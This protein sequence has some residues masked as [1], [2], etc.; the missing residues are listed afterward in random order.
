MTDALKEGPAP[1]ELSLVLIALMKGVLYKA[2]QP[3]LWEILLR[4]HAQV[5]DYVGVL[6]LQL[7]LSDAEGYAYLRQIEAVEEEELPR[8]VARRQLGYHVSLLLALLRKKLAEHDTAGGDPRLILT[9]DQIADTL[10]LFL[11]ETADEVRFMRRI[12]RDINQ[13]VEM[14]FIRRLKG[15]EDR[16]EVQRIIAS[17]VDAQWL[18]DFERKLAQYRELAMDGDE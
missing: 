5:S 12:D 15:H 3:H 9:R 4:L 18:S 10:R 7:F 6:G 14:G 2:Q 17:F 16:F 8:L 11:P 13:I 1:R